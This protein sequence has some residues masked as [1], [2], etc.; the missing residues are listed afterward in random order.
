MD[1]IALLLKSYRGDHAYAERLLDSFEQFNAEGLTLHCVV[2]AADRAMFADPARAN[3]VVHAEE[4]VAAGHLV[5]APIGDLRK[6]YANQEIV[7]LSFWETGLAANYFCV[8]SDAVFLRPFGADDFMHDADTPYTVLVEDNDLKIEPR[9]YREHWVGREA[10]IRRIMA[11]VGLDERVMR[12]C[13]GHQVFNSRVLESFVRDFLTPQGLTYAGALAISPYEF[14]W[15]AMWLQ[16]ARPIQIHQREPLVKVFHDADQY[17][18]A[19]M[20]GLTESDIARGYLAVVVNS[21]FSR[22]LGPLSLS[23]D[24]PAALAPHLSYGEIARLMRSKVAASLH[25]RLPK[26]AGSKD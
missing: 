24:K 22:S 23:A 25:G 19:T 1:R 13:H 18:A 6:G 11:E 17:L 2:P 14:S 10:A 26:Q 20:M 16:K 9:Y 12:T 7:K 5:D 8:D 15:Y 3:V 21:N 4:D